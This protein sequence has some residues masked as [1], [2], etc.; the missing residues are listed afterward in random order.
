M[1]SAVGTY[2]SD[3]SEAR[4]L[5][6]VWNSAA[7]NKSTTSKEI[8]FHPIRSS[9][10]VE[11]LVKSDCF[12]TSGFDQQSKPFSK[13]LR[14]RLDTYGINA[15]VTQERFVRETLK[16]MDEHNKNTSDD[17]K[18]T[19]GEKGRS[20][21]DAMKSRIA[22]LEKQQS[23]ADR[24]RRPLDLQAKRVKA[25]LK[26]T[27]QDNKKLKAKLKYMEGSR[28]FAKVMVGGSCLAE[29]NKNIILGNEK[30]VKPAVG[31]RMSLPAI[32]NKPS[33]VKY[34]IHQHL[35][36]E[37]KVVEAE[38]CVMKSRLA[39]MEKQMEEREAQSKENVKMMEE[40]NAKMVAKLKDE[41]ASTDTRAQV[42]EWDNQELRL[43]VEELKEKI[44]SMDVHIEALAYSGDTAW[45]L[46]S[47]LEARVEQLEEE[48][49]HLVRNKQE[50]VL[51]Q[52]GDDCNE[53]GGSS[54]QTQQQPSQTGNDPSC[55]DENCRLEKEALALEVE[56][57][58]QLRDLGGD[59]KDGNNNNE[60]VHLLHSTR[61]GDQ[62]LQTPDDFESEKLGTAMGGLDLGG[63]GEAESLLLTPGDLEASV[64]LP[65]QTALP[66]HDCIDHL[67]DQDVCKGLESGDADENGDS[68]KELTLAPPLQTP[69]SRSE[70]YASIKRSNLTRVNVTTTPPTTPVDNNM[71]VH[72][73]DGTA[74]SE[75]ESDDSDRGP[76]RTGCGSS[77]RQALA[78]R[79]TNQKKSSP[80]VK[81]ATNDS[82]L[83]GKI[84]Q[85]TKT[86]KSP[87]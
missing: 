84:D 9:V 59:L 25:E 66:C 1:K 49:S 65:F 51:S 77:V 16:A 27:A 32:N 69:M 26:E 54:P 67:S 75:I 57:L 58:K 30:T 68:E 41:L 74:A 79:L 3:S 44:K 52:A 48:N 10:L 36:N 70:K 46:S 38:N 20:E 78:K 2:S 31:K 40:I 18:N 34:N 86:H 23:V 4:K 17:K 24:F 12:S 64:E 39:S 60:E 45:E 82:G 19:R 71:P 80:S 50:G 42:A 28:V 22:R 29:K 33:Q 81:P 37:M 7:L 6:E 8:S 15:V 63:S 61:L 83:G 35:C 56:L 62:E 14:S 72:N 85:E 13:L 55:T 73:F 43:E 76:S 21:K 87:N 5:K 47:S 11:A 53:L